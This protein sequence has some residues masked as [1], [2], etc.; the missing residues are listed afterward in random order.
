MIGFT[1]QAFID[2]HTPILDAAFSGDL[3]AQGI[4]RAMLLEAYNLDPALTNLKAQMFD[5]V[6]VIMEVLNM[7]KKDEELRSALF[8]RP[9]DETSAMQIIMD[10]MEKIN[11]EPRFNRNFECAQAAAN[12]EHQCFNQ[13]YVC[14]FPADRTPPGVPKFPKPLTNDEG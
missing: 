11:A 14:R 2:Y 5:A 4:I 12:P 13:C 7:A 10:F 6:T 3:E 1:R 9:S 8:G